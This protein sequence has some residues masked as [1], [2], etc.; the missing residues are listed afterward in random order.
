MR[1]GIDAR[2]WSQTGV[3]RYIRNIVYQLSLIDKSN[4]YFIYLLDEDYDKVNL[5]P[6]FKKIKTSVYWHTLSEQTILLIDYL[7]RNLDLLFVPNF[8]VPIFYPKK[9]VVT[10]HDLTLLRTRTGRSTRLP[11]FL[12][13]IKYLAGCFNHFVAVK[14]SAKIFTVS[15]YVK[16]DIVKTFKVNP[17]KI[18]LTPNAV[19]EKFYRRSD[20]EVRA[21]LKKYGVQKPYFFYVGNAC[22]HKNLSRLVEAFDVFCSFN[23][24][25]YLVLGGRKDFNYQNLEHKI[26]SLKCNQRIKIIG[27]V[28][29]EDLPALY[30]GASLYINPSLYEGF[31][32]Q[33][34]E[35][36]ACGCRVVCS[37]TTSLPEVAGDLAT[38]FNPLDVNDI[39]KKLSEALLK[40]DDDFERKA[41]NHVLFYSW[42]KSASTIYKEIISML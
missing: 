35:A 31:G 21:V 34:L 18:V 8:N 37:N 10:V 9:F 39:A 5:P 12:Y 36:Y 32:I 3:G 33:I 13:L 14:R 29:D 6:N 15:N 4:E 7:R 40:I 23:S 17:K 42:E 16:E 2:F 27:Y 24:G 22:L 30:S 26:K 28:D 20:S 41:K 38:Y 11:Y 25:F 19:D 1:I